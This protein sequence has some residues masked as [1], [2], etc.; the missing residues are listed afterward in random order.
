MIQKL[1]F[2]SHE[3]MKMVKYGLVI[4]L[5]RCMGCRACVA[6]CKVENFVQPENYWLYVLEWEIG[7]YPNVRRVFVPMNCMHCENPPCL[8]ACPVD[9][10]E[11]NEQG[12][13]LINY[14]KCIGCRYCIAACPY[15]VI[16]YI[17]K[18]KTLY[19]G[20]TTPYENIPDDLRHWTHVKRDNIVE[21]CTLCW[22]RIEKA[23]RE[24]RKP[25]SDPES[26]PACVLVC[27]VRARFFGDL[28][29]PNSEVSKLIAQKKATQLKKE[30]GTRPQVYYI[31]G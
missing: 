12:V 24:G 3:V 19:S 8:K 27:P 11:K 1:E 13:V 23:L 22:H 10:I 15:G 6:A 31:M 16:H 25:G 4:D 2:T 14:E 26:T 7:K 28:D 21:K 17:E 18:K 9:A 5:K 30:Y 29:D 20:Y